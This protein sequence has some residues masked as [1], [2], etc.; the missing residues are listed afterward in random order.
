M[1]ESQTQ[2]LQDVIEWLA[3]LLRSPITGAPL[4]AECGFCVS[5]DGTERYPISSSGIVVFGEA[6]LSDAARAQ[7]E[8][9]DAV[10]KSYLTNLGYPHTQE[11]MAYLDR[12]VLAEIPPASLGLTAELCCGRGEAFVLLGDRIARGVGLDVS[13]RMLEAARTS[14]PGPRY[15]FIQ[16][17]ATRLPLTEGV[18]DTVV[19]LGGIHHIPDRLALFAEIARIL[20][21]GGKFF[22]REPL[23]D[24]FLWRLIR[25]LVYRI[26]PALDHRTERPL[27]WEETVPVLDRV[28]L[29]CTK[30]RSCGFLGFCLFMNSD[31]LV[32]N[33][34]FR[35]I[36]GIRWLTR[37]STKF[38]ELLLNFSPLRG[39]GLQVIG[40]VEK[41]RAE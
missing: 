19:M 16:A 6:W 17:D 9:Y 13:V 34:L 28:N 15:A 39:A 11:Y 14:L 30:W 23:D 35:F 18:F 7:G 25:K 22:F 38:D 40:V 37:L 41:S 10:A 27:R 32:F 36:P 2:P 12:A 31:V 21:P 33:R 1:T 8:H 3:P 4:R 24:F 20:K 5:M 29:K 26:S